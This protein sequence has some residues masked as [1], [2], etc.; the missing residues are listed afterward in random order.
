MEEQ[1][2]FEPPQLSRRQAIQAGAGA[3][4]GSAAMLAG[5]GAL[6]KLS[7]QAPAPVQATPLPATDPKFP[8]PPMWN[9]EL[10]QLAPNV[11][12]YTQGGGPGVS[13]SGVSNPGMIARSAYLLA[14]DATH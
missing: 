9:R 5:A 11:Y 13:A 2:K 7:A 10:R 6:E 12:A 14:Y 8:M 3:L 4:L 1:N